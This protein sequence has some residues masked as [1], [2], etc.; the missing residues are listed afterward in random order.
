M[1]LQPGTLYVVVD[2]AIT[3]FAV[4]AAPN[5]VYWYETEADAHM[6]VLPSE[7]VREVTT[8]AEFERERGW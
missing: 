6:D 1:A 4:L 3:Q 8:Q 5:K 7:Y 2:G